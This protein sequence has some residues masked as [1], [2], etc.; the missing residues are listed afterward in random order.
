MIF[1]T[2]FYNNTQ[3]Q[4]IHYWTKMPQEEITEW[5]SREHQNVIKED[6]ERYQKLKK[7]VISLDKFV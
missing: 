1:Q 2:S 4:A 3:V 5:I 7:K 6:S